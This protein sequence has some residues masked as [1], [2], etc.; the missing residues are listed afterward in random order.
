MYNSC[1]LAAKLAFYTFATLLYLVI[2]GGFSQFII[3][4]FFF[5]GLYTLHLTDMLDIIQGNKN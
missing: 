4:R 3:A 1:K 5:V 2:C